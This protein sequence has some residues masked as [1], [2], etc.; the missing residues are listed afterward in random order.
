MRLVLLLGWFGKAMECY[1]CGA[2]MYI[3]GDHDIEDLDTGADGIVTNL[4]CSN[5]QCNTSIEIYH[6]FALDDHQFVGSVN[7]QM[8]TKQ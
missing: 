2:D 3:G 4:S 1:H 8:A 7:E 6:Y 5:E